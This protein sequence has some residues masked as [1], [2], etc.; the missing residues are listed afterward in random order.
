MKTKKILA[1]LIS[2]V[3][4]T[5]MASQGA[6]IVTEK[7]SY[8]DGAL[9]GNNGGTGD[10]SGAWAGDHS[11]SGG[12]ISTATTAIANRSFSTTFTGSS[13]DPLYFSARFTKTG[14]DTEYALW[15][16][17][18]DANSG[19][20]NEGV[21]FGLNSAGFTVGL[22]NGGGADDQIFGTYTAGE[23]V[24]IIG[25][26]E[27][28][29]DGVNERAQIWVNPTGEET[30]TIVSSQI[31]LDIGWTTPQ[32]SFVRNWVGSDG[33]FLVDDIRVGSTWAA[34]V[35]EPSSTALL[36]LGGL[37][38]MLRRKRS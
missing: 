8:S 34:A 30:A 5:T 26:L 28:N 38:L 32:F 24:Q 35:P 15:V 29:V 23:Q 11:V 14:S 16:V 37:A 33:D 1:L 9:A 31:T 22:E 4:A 27:F 36:G 18:D 12:Q 19:I 17:L 20:N 13:S 7:F 10:W 6:V 21:K 2:G 3:F 25:K